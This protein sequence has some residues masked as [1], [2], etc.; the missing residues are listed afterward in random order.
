MEFLMKLL[1]SNPRFI[2]M[3]LTFIRVGMGI[4]FMIHGYF[5]LMGG[6]TKWLWLGQQM[7]M[8]GIT[9]A[10]VLWGFCAMLSELI[11]GTCLTIGL[12]TRIAAFFLSCV[13]FVALVFH[14][15]QGDPYSQLSFPLSQLIVFIGFI[16]AGGGPWSVDNQITSI[17]PTFANENSFQ[18]R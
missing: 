16:I 1:T 5:K 9:F 18:E 2:V 8:F 15:K 3:G 11:G 10:P 13:M 17:N 14:I 7:S 6:S 4:S 12:G